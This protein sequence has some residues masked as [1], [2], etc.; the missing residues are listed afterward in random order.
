MASAK[1]EVFWNDSLVLGE[2][3][4]QQGKFGNLFAQ[5]AGG[6]GIGECPGPGIGTEIYRTVGI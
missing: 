2:I 6:H 3:D 4:L 1:I 5:A